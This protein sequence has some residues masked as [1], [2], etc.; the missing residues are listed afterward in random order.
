V[1]STK[2]V[3]SFKRE[4]IR[5]QTQSKAKVNLQPSNVWVQLKIFWAPPRAWVTSSAMPFVAHAS[6]SRLQMPVLHCCCCCSWWSSHC[7][8]ISKTLHDPFSPGPSIATEAGLSPMAFLGLSQ[9]QASAAL[10]NSF[11]GPCALSLIPRIALLGDGE[12][13]EIEAWGCR[14]SSVNRVL[15]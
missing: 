4:N 6:S 13:C 15:T 14:W 1:G 9:C 8:G 5:A 10:L 2:T 3:S 7:T 12:T 11:R